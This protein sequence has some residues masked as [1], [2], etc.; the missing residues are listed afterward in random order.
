MK[1]KIRMYP[2]GQSMTAEGRY[3][4]GGNFFSWHQR[5]TSRANEYLQQRYSISEVRTILDFKF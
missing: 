3:G 2:R 4:G 5:M 1:V